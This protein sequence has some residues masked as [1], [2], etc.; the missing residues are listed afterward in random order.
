MRRA[1]ALA[2]TAATAVILAAAVPAT[3]L[4]RSFA[5]DACSTQAALSAPVA[6]QEQAMLCLSNAARRSRGL[7]ELATADSLTRAARRKSADVVR[8]DSFDHEACGRPFDYWIKQ[9]G[10]RGCAVA[11]N[12]AW[13]SG[14]LGNVRSIFRAWMRSAGHRENILGRYEEIGIGLRVGGLDGVRGAHVWTQDFGA[15]C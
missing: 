12:I 9:L 14:R 10:Y 4:P 5:T 7:P 11:E 1:V 3:A 13:G 8:C 15:P 2:T 6:V